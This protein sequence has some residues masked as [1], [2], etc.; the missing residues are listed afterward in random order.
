MAFLTF[1]EKDMTRHPERITA[2]RADFVQHIH[3]LT[4]NVA[5]DLDTP[6]NEND[7]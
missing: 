5:V 6:L 2:L 7:E 4:R 3:E 1:L